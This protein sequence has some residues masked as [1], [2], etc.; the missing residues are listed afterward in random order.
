MPGLHGLTTTALP[1]MTQGGVINGINGHT[2]TANGINGHAKEANGTYAFN[3]I[4]ESI[5]A[6]GKTTLVRSSITLKDI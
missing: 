2:N 6:I 5:E 1:R 4:E 3:T